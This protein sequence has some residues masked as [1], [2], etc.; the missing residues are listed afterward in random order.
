M[1]HTG[2]MLT[3]CGGMDTLGWKEVCTACNVHVTVEPKDGGSWDLQWDC[4]GRSVRAKRATCI[5]Q[6]KDEA[7]WQG[8]TVPSTGSS[9]SPTCIRRWRNESVI[10]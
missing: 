1:V 7:Y 4:A 2:V 5:R 9:G 8:T 6:S 10:G 3:T